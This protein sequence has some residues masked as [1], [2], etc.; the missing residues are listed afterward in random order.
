MTEGLIER[1]RN[2]MWA[3]SDTPFESPQLERDENIA[4]MN[5]AADE[6]LRLRATIDQLRLVAGAVSAEM[7]L[8]GDGHGR[9][10]SKPKK[11]QKR[12]KLI[13]LFLQTEWTHD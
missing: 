5:E 13:R 10:F 7:P 12:K 8:L 4:A 6:I 2:P 11:F 9:T 3:H 1:L